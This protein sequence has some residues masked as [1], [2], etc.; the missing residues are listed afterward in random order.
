MV[1]SVI[2]HRP[3]ELEVS[4]AVHGWWKRRPAELVIESA[5]CGGFGNDVHDSFEEFVYRF[6]LEN[7]LWFALHDRG[8]MPE[9]GEEYLAFH[10][11]KSRDAN[12]TAG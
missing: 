11:A 12:S 4:A 6:W 3:G 10:R 2:F 5:A 7:E 9:G 8:S 1:G